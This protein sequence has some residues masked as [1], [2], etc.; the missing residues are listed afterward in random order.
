M[1]PTPAAG[2][3]SDIVVIGRNPGRQERDAGEP[4][5]GSCAPYIDE[6][7]AACGI[8]RN[9]VYIT[10]LVKCF[11]TANREPAL[12][13]SQACMKRFL[14]P[15]IKLVRPKVLLLM[16]DH[17]TKMLCGKGVRDA[18]PYSY[19]RHR[20]FSRLVGHDC[21]VFFCYHPG[22]CVRGAAAWADRC[23]QGFERVARG[24]AKVL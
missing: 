7:L 9:H 16:G 23:R 11:T 13:Q 2:A 10:N 3:P 21:Y 22:V 4:F 24:L 17:V 5:V 15:E 20:F 1:R 6:W 18:G 8:G 12:E 19:S 14:V